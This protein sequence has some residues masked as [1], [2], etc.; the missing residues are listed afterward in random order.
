[1]SIETINL[2]LAP[3]TVEKTTA[4]REAMTNV[5]N[6]TTIRDTD[7]DANFVSIDETWYEYKN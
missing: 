7:L 5:K 3:P 2:P 6:L 1:M 4:E